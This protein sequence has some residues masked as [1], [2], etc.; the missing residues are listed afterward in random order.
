HRA[1]EGDPVVRAA[2]GFGE[3]VGRR[4][5]EGWLLA[6]G[7]GRSRGGKQQH[8]PDHDCKQSPWKS[9]HTRHLS[10]YRVTIRLRRWN[11]TRKPLDSWL[12]PVLDTFRL[13]GKV[14]LV[15]G[16]SRGLGLQ[17]AEGLGEAGASVAI[18]ARREEGLAQAVSAL[19]GR[20][21]RAMS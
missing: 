6:L 20:G 3:L 16:G 10:G 4:R 5:A 15:T 17:I 7:R 13:D 14:A 9:A 8:A 18:T 11:S 21:I 19:E 1:A 12:M 2:L